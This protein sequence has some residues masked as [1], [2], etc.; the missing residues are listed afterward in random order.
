[1]T[2]RKKRAFASIAEKNAVMENILR[3][4]KDKQTFLILG[5]IQADEDCISSMVSVSLVLAKFGKSPMIYLSEPFPEQMQ[6]IQNICLYNKIPI[7]R[8]SAEIKEAPDAIFVVDT[9]KPSMI[10]ADEKIKG[11]FEK[12]TAMEVD[13]H[14]GADA[15]YC[16]NDGLCYVD[17]STSACAL[18]A[19]ICLKLDQR[20]ELLQEY[21]IEEFFTRNIVL[22]L[23]TGIIGDTKSGTTLKTHRERFFYNFFAN[24]LTK[25]LRDAYRQNSGNYTDT[26]EI[27]AAISQLSREE[28]EVYDALMPHA[29]FTAQT[30]AIF[31]SKEESAEFLDKY[32]SDLLVKVLK[33]VT[34]ALAEQS[35]RVGTTSYYDTPSG[36]GK[37]QYRLRA[38]QGWSAVDFRD[39]LARF[40]ITDGGGHPGAVGFRFK[41]T[42]M[43]EAKVKAFNESLIPVLDAL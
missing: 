28:R 1:M 12:A 26:A 24:Y 7:L 19:A 3:A 27:F 37:I 9:P 18:L 30:G 29:S 41:D 22:C 20:K 34:D 6:Y 13:H 14:L 8:D 5:H 38:A 36:G 43:D 39:V 11:F 25:I 10:L 23:L 33:I 15:E 4:A 32:G 21:G 17:D 42:E 16:G 2:D 40:N 35:G 31:L